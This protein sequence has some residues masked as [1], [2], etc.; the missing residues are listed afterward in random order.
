MSVYICNIS[1]RKFQV[2]V[3]ILFIGVYM[4]TNIS[5]KRMLVGVGLSEKVY[6]IFQRLNEKKLSVWSESENRGS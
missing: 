1:R 2:A 5:S 6:A 4:Y 3:P